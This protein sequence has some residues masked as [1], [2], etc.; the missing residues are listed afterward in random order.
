[1]LSGWSDTWL[2]VFDNLDNPSYFHDIITFF[3][4]SCWGCILVTSHFAGAKELD[5]VIVLDCMEK[6]E[7]LQLLLQGSQEDSTELVA[8]EEILMKLGYLPLAIDQA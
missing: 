5:S 3:P 4:Q 1:M 8:T 6:D 7:G 2:L